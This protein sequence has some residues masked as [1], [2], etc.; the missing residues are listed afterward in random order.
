[1]YSSK[2]MVNSEQC[3][4]SV[5][6]NSLKSIFDVSLF[7]NP[8]FWTIVV[9]NNFL[10]SF[11]ICKLTTSMKNNSSARK[12]LQKLDGL[13]NFY[14]LKNCCHD[15]YWK[16]FYTKYECSFLFHLREWKKAMLSNSLWAF[17]YMSSHSRLCHFYKIKK[18]VM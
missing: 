16:L 7:T 1:M 8:S 14:A 6:I 13:K 11:Q 15:F 3:I 9:K 10:H 18:N 5:K 4:V 12:F 17:Q 2:L